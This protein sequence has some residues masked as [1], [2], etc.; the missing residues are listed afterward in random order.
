MHSLGGGD[1]IRIRRPSPVSPLRRPCRGAWSG[2]PGDRQS[3]GPPRA[4][5]R[6][7][8]ARDRRAVH[9]SQGDRRRLRA[10]RAELEEGGAR[11]G[12]AVHGAALRALAGFRRGVRGAPLEDM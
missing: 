12:A 6:R 9:R 3:R 5:E 4:P 2:C 1:H 7:Q 11:Y 8:A 10:G